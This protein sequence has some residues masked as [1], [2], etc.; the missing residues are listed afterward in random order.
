MNPKLLPA[1]GLSMTV[2]GAFKAAD[3]VTT[4]VLLQY[5]Y[6]YHVAS[7]PGSNEAWWR[8][9]NEDTRHCGTSNEA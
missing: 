4:Y 1:L 3:E 8:P 6:M 9:G 5:M 7:L 2:S